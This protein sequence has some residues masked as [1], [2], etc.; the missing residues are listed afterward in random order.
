MNVADYL[1]AVLALLFVLLL[2]WGCAWIFRKSGL[3]HKIQP[4]PTTNDSACLEIIAMQS[5]DMRHRAYLLKC[6]EQEFITIIGGT[7]PTIVALQKTTPSVE[8][9]S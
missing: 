9:V 1:N 2:L 3:L 8:S 4:Q 7:T 6:R 5:L